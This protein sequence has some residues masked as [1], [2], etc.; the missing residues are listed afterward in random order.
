[1][2]APTVLQVMNGIK[3]RLATITGLAT[4]GHTPSQIN[5]PTAIVGVPA[6]PN[7]HVS[8][9]RGQMDLDF[10][11]VVLVS[12]VLDQ[13]GQEKLAGYADP[14]GTTSVAA[15][16]EGDRTLGGIV[17]YAFVSAF[18]PLGLEEVGLLSYYGGVFTVTVGTSGS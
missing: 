2:A 3:T 5:G 7:Y 1:M 10:D 11:V 4:S 8:M 9:A 6:I 14:T 13:V 15:A 16:V 18:R 12:A 17:D